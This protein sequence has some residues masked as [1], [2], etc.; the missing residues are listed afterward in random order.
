MDTAAYILGYGIIYGLAI[1]VV[2]GI[3]AF[4]W[5]MLVCLINKLKLVRATN[6]AMLSEK[7]KKKFMPKTQLVLYGLAKLWTMPWDGTTIS[8]QVD[9]YWGVKYHPGW[10]PKAYV[11]GKK[12]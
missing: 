5:L 6:G 7:W 10:W 4:H 9:G 11:N 3:L 1:S 12:I 8:Y 2:S